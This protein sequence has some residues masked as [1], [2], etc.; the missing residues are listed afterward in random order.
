[1]LISTITAI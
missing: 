1:M